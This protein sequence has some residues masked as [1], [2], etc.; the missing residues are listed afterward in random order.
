MEKL[1]E[2]DLVIATMERDRLIAEGETRVQQLREQIKY[3]YPNRESF[4][5]FLP[6]VSFLFAFIYFI[7]HAPTHAGVSTTP[8]ERTVV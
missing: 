3:E 1:S 6:C 8:K 2:E 4:S 5:F 7:Y